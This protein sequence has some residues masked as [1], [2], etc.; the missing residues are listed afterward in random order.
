MQNNF[1]NIWSKYQCGF[2]K[3]YNAQHCL[4]ALIEKWKQS[5]DNGGA[6]GALMIDLSKAFDCL[7]H[8][9]LIAKLDALG[10]D[11]KSIKLVHNY[12]SNRKQRVKINGSYSSSRE[13]LYG[14]SQ[15]LIWT[16]A[17]QYF[18]TRYVLFLEDYEVANYADD[19]TPSSA[20]RNHQCVIEELEKIF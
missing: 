6:F 17:F 5:V 18:Y 15:D 2:R 3:G 1:G 16:F 9:L 13:I 11:K 14:V 12:L 4:I 7:P 19:A 20:Q 8:E 10:S